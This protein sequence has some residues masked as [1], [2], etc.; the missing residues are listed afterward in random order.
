MIFPRLLCVA[1][2]AWHR[3]DWELEHNREKREV[4]QAVDWSRFATVM[5]TRELSRLD[6]NGV[7]YHLPPPGARLL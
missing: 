5:G 3:A 4:Q 6:K 2:R 1:E 7:A